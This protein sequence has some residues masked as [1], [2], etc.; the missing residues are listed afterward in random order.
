MGT[1]KEINLK[2]SNLITFANQYLEFINPFNHLSR[3]EKDILAHIMT[4]D[5]VFIENENIKEKM[6]LD[7]DVKV[8]IME[9]LDITE[10]RLNNVISALRKKGVIIKT[11]NGNKLHD[12]YDLTEIELPFN[13]TFIWD[14]E[15]QE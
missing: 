13:L 2:V 11:K 12:A 1:T 5:N 9:T 8:H 4:S 15:N 3:G 6:L 10:A 14:V 7:Y